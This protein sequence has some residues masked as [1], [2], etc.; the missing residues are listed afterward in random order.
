MERNVWDAIQEQ[1]AFE[2]PFGSYVT[3]DDEVLTDEHL[4]ESDIVQS[5]KES[6]EETTVVK[7]E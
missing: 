6:K 2:L 1:M 4:T 5:I 7:S 3:E